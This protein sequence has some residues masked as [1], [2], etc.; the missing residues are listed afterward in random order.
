MTH[1][2]AYGNEGIKSIAFLYYDEARPFM[3]SLGLI[4]SFSLMLFVPLYNLAN[5]EFL[6]VFNFVSKFIYN[7][8]GSMNRA[9]LLAYRWTLLL[10]TSATALLTDEVEVVLNLAG[11]IAI[12][13]I[14]F[15]LP[16][17]YIPYF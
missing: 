15:Y 7:K 16:V 3:Q 12:P 4:F 6:E 11:S 17:S 5:S 9:K 10:L 13:I 8:N 2:Q 1:S 14:S